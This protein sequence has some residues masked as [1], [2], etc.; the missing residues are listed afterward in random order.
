MARL[1]D[2]TQYKIGEAQPYGS[3]Y[4]YSK[5]KYPVVV[6]KNGELVGY[7]KEERVLGADGSVVAKTYYTRDL[8][9]P[10]GKER[11]YATPEALLVGFGGQLYSP[12]PFEVKDALFLIVILDKDGTALSP[13]LF[14]QSEDEALKLGADWL[15]SNH[16]VI[17]PSTEPNAVLSSWQ[18]LGGSYVLDAYDSRRA[19]K[20]TDA[21]GHT[22]LLVSPEAIDE[23]TQ[24]APVTAGA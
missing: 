10:A 14:A 7:I 16:A 3:I 20:T 9:R 15:L 24:D 21:P 11:F 23:A 19:K 4:G 6:A 22:D 17:A 1:Y 12:I 13:Q 18:E 8:E 2:N 5:L